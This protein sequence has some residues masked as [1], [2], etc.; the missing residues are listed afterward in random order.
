M[1]VHA[2]EKSLDDFVNLLSC[3]MRPYRQTE[4]LIC[5][6]LSYGKGAPPPAFPNV[7]LLQVWWN[8]VMNQCANAFFGQH[9]LQF[10][11]L[12]VLHHI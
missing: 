8:G 2:T 10:V 3:D 1:I 6:T 12:R 7:N 11:A 9:P 4:Y 5:Q